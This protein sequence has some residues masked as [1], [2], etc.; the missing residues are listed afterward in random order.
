MSRHYVYVDIITI[1]SPVRECGKRKDFGL[2]ILGGGISDPNGTLKHFY[3]LHPP[4]PYSVPN[5]RIPRMVDANTVLAR[6]PLEKWWVD[7]SARTEVRKA[8]IAWEIETF[9]MPLKDRLTLGEC[10]YCKTAQAA[11]ELITSK[12]MWS[13]R[14]PGYF[15]EIAD[16][17]T[18]SRCAIP[19]ETLRAALH[20]G[21]L[22]QA[23]A[24]IWQLRALLPKRL[25]HLR[26]TLMRMLVVM[27]LGQDAIEMP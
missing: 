10:R 15:R 4:I 27:G 23:Q 11:A 8:G 7:S 21:D 9:G 6:E 12:L 22:F 17:G 14:L 19:Y 5:H 26:N 1:E 16:A 24:A 18:D 3:E 2:Y 25:L 13:D 20:K